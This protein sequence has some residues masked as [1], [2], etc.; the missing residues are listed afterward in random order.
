MLDENYNV[1][2]IDFGLSKRFQSKDALMST[3][4]GTPGYMAPEV[5]QNRPY[6]VECD[7]WSAGIVLYEMLTG[8]KPF[9]ETNESIHYRQVLHSEPDY[10]GISKELADLIALLLKKK[11][12]ERIP[13][14]NILSYPYFQQFSYTEFL[15][16]KIKELVLMKED[17]IID[18]ELE[19]TL[20]PDS[21]SVMRH[22]ITKEKITKEMVCLNQL[23]FN[24]LEANKASRQGP[25]VT[26]NRRLSN[27][28]IFR[29]NLRTQTKDDHQEN[30]PKEITNSEEF[31]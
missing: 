6:Q 19:K 15:N 26:R 11:P 29:R 7:I 13:L 28:N 4:C 17:D 21:L 20:S 2:L 18:P 1:R 3:N 9:D 12:Q 27:P 31:H 24:V 5:L 25:R 8:K 10:T 16:E 14:Q 23:D 30:P 22:V